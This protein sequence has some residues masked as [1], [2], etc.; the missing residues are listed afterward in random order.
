[1]SLFLNTGNDSRM[2]EETRRNM[3]S[4]LAYNNENALSCIISILCI[5]IENQYK[6]IRE[7]P[8]EKGFADIVLVP[9]P[10]VMKPAIVIELKFKQDVKA[11][12]DQIREN[13]YPD[14][15]KDFY[16]EVVLVGISYSKRKAHECFVE[17]F[18]REEA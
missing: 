9:K 14:D 15:I 4:I 10:K 8:T 6:I 2:V 17:R 12:I 13:Q 7:M 11:A 16:G 3:T 5:A 18:E 1:M